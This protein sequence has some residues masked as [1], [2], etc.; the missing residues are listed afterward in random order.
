MLLPVIICILLLVSENVVFISIGW[1]FGTLY[2][3]PNK[4]T[5]GATGFSHF[6]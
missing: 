6:L 1:I 5:V 3:M 2:V 4:S